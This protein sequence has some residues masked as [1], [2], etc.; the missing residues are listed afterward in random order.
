MIE[1]EFWDYDSPEE[2]ADAVAGDIGFIVE[3]AIDARGNALLAFPGGTTPVPVFEKLAHS[4]VPWKRVTIIP[5]DERLL[6][7]LIDG[8]PTLFVRRDEVE[9]QWQWIDGVRAAWTS[10][11]LAPQSYDAGSRGPAAADALARIDGVEWHD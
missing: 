8:N 9:A 1:A 2:M 7:D 4:A 3:S 10:A 6:L 11:G 5:G